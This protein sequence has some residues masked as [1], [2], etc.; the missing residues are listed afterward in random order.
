MSKLHVLS[1]DLRR[2]VR[3][4]IDSITRLIEELSRNKEGITDQVQDRIVNDIWS[5]QSHHGICFW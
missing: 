4:G 5:H 2:G 3:P 1:M